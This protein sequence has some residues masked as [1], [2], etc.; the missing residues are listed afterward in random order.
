M[1]EVDNGDGELDVQEFEQAVVRVMDMLRNLQ[2]VELF[3]CFQLHDVDSTGA[4]SIDEVFDIL[5]ELGMAPRIEQENE[6]IRQCVAKVDVD[7]SNEVDFN[8]FEQLLLEVRE[9][10]HRMRRERR[11]HIIQQCELEREIVEAFKNEICELKDQ[12]DCYDKDQSG[13]LDRS[14]LNLLI[15][16]CGLGPRSKKERE[17]IQALIDSS[18]ADQ[19]AQVTF[20]EFLHLI[21]GIRHLSKARCLRDLQKLFERFD[22]DGN[23]NMSLPECCRLLEHLGLAPKTQQ[24]QRH[25]A[26]LLEAI[27]EDGNCELDFEEFAHLCQRVTE[28]L[29]V[30]AHHKQLKAAKSLSIDIAQLQEY[31][32]VFENMDAEE[33]GQLSMQCVRKMLDSLHYNISGDDLNEIFNQVDENESGFI[34]FTEFLKLISV[35]HGHAARAGVYFRTQ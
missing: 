1:E 20:T 11:R 31:K 8:E 14:E 32:L 21:R 6:M 27:D 16:D 23:G 7:N 22:K 25:I 26:V 3:E 5:P 9:R 12:F 24:E 17:E 4:L 18:D 34:E 35:V 13:F 19:N 15:A 33:T 30:A 10:M 28:M 29:Q 2:S